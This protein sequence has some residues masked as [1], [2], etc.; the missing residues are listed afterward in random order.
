MKVNVCADGGFLCDQCIHNERERID[1]VDPQCLD[2]DQWRIIGQQESTDTEKCDHCGQII[3]RDAT[4]RITL[5][6]D[7]DACVINGVACH[8]HGC[9]SSHINLAT[10]KPHIIPCFWCGS[11]I[12]ADKTFCDDE[13]AAAYSEV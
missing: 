8:E 12:P 11:P 10:G 4:V 6:S 7:C 9:P 5:C 1:E 13:C 2:D 3:L